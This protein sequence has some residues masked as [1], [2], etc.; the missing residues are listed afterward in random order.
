MDLIL[1]VCEIQDVTFGAFG[2]MQLIAKKNRADAI[3]REEKTLKTHNKR[4]LEE[5]ENK[6]VNISIFNRSV[7]CLRFKDISSHFQVFYKKLIW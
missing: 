1:T 6:M 3:N 7:K 5:N 4:F 2:P